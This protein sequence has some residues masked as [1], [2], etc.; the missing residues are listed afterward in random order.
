MKTLATLALGCLLLSSAVVAEG[1]TIT[2]KE[3]LQGYRLGSTTSDGSQKIAPG[4]ARSMS[5]DAFGRRFDINL[6]ENRSLFS[7]QQ[8][9][10]LDSD[11]GIYRGDIAGIAGSWVRL[12]VADDMPRGMLWDGVELWAINVAKDPATGADSP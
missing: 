1:I 9:K 10:R 2:Y 4:T 7:K 5:F 11:Y 6:V 3:P 8:R 12:V